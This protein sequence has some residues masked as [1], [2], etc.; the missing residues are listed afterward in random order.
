MPA[1]A[2]RLVYERSK[3]RVCLHHEPSV[4]DAVRLVVELLRR[5]GIEL[6]EHRL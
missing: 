6:V 3:A 4:A 2:D 5:H 1:R